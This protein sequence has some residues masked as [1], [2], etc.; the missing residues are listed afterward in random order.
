LSPG[1]GLGYTERVG[2]RRSPRRRSAR[3][4]LSPASLAFPLVGPPAS[5]PVDTDPQEERRVRNPSWSLISDYKAVPRELTPRAQRLRAGGTV[6][7]VREGAERGG[8]ARPRHG[9]EQ[10]VRLRG[11]GQ[12]RRGAGGHPGDA[13]AR[14]R[15]PPADGGRGQAPQVSQWRQFR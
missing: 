14:G 1:D 11:D 12:R 5:V 8:H 6:L 3:T 13:G 10:G 2:T 9:P 7:R 15:G 4:L